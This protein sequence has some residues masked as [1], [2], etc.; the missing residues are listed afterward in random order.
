MA[1]HKDEPFGQG[2]GRFKKQD[3]SEL[4]ELLQDVTFKGARKGFFIPD[5]ALFPIVMAGVEYHKRYPEI[6]YRLAQTL[7]HTAY[8]E[9]EGEK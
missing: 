8:W 4:K 1:K 3:L 7:A 5:A 2:P 6:P 9:M